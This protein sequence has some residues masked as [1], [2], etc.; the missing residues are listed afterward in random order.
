MLKKKMM[1]KGLFISR[2]STL[3]TFAVKKSVSSCFVYYGCCRLGAPRQ[4]LNTE[5]AAPERTRF[6]RLCG[7]HERGGSLQEPVSSKER[8]KRRGGKEL[9]FGGAGH[10]RIGLPQSG[11]WGPEYHLETE[12]W[13]DFKVEESLGLCAELRASTGSNDLHLL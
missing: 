6:G 8:K 9:W 2:F 4:V 3:Q 1:Y 13:A 12:I 11:C 5:H 10:G 7:S